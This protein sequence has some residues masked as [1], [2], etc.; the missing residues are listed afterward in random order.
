MSINITEEK[1]TN[2][3]TLTLPLAT[4]EER[5]LLGKDILD[6]VLQHKW[7]SVHQHLHEADCVDE[8]NWT[9]LHWAIREYYTPLE[10]INLLINAYPPAVSHKDVDGCLPLHIALEYSRPLDV[11]KSLV[12]SCPNTLHL[13]DKKG[14]TPLHVACNKS[15][16]TPSQVLEYLV[17]EHPE[18][19]LKK[20]CMG[21]TPLIEA[22]VNDLEE[23]VIESLLR[24]CP[25]SASVTHEKFHTPLHLAVNQNNSVR[26]IR[27]LVKC[28]PDLISSNM[29]MQTAED[30]FYH[31][32]DR[33][34]STFLESVSSSAR[35]SD[36]W[37]KDTKINNFPIQQI[38]HIACFF[39][40]NKGDIL[41]NTQPSTILHLAIKSELCPWSFCELFLRLHPH[42]CLNHSLEGTIELVTKSC[43]RKFYEPQLV[44]IARLINRLQKKIKDF[45]AE[46]GSKQAALMKLLSATKSNNEELQMMNFLYTS[47]R[48]NPT[49]CASKKRKQN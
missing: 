28:Q 19:G 17:K 29:G 40:Q 27:A 25:D 10:T 21:N 36:I 9:T 38:Y 26:I 37:N 31:K 15:S 2:P 16:N 20:D 18:A 45:C 39:L 33:P 35:P 5:D 42:E 34:L 13:M 6:A 12:E 14:R 11:I 23:E 30:L 1:M 48:E 4:A 44:Q 47:I 3:N 24:Y 32:W 22:I 7:D 49:V 41:H 46:G 43:K 8:D